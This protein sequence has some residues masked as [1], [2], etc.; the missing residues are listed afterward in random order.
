MKKAVVFGSFVVDLMGRSPHLP[1]PG[2]TVKGSL[3]KMGPGG[4]GA[5][6]AVA[7]KRAGADVAIITK[8][9]KDEFAQIAKR[10]FLAEGLALTYVFE[11]QSGAST[12]AALILV[13]EN[14]GQN[15][16]SVLP[17]AC[18]T[19][20]E[21]EVE[22]ASGIIRQSDFLLTQLETNLTAMYAAVRMAKKSGAKVILNPAPAVPVDPDMYE[23]LY[24]VTPNEV[25]AAALSGIE[26]ESNE[27][28]DR[29]AAFFLEKGCENVIITLGDRGAYLKTPT[30][31][32]FFK[33]IEVPVVDTTGA[34]DAFNGGLLAG[35][36]E[37]MSLSQAT[38]FAMVAAGLSV[39]KLGTAPAMPFKEEIEAFLKKQ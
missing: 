12:G 6:Q 10:N 39:T 15:A 11:D 18:E 14:T 31:S 24:C 23:G 4:K 27:G 28:I 13:D 20:T 25:E 1:V 35:L 5:N 34:G 9:G 2:E 26:T 16:I 30:Q 33:T 29:A 8:L 7:A 22:K 21:E 17:G 36:A 37:G 38:A 3:F 19:I 32:E